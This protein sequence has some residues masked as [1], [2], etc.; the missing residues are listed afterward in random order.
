MSELEE[1][2]HY[3][4]EE[5]EAK[6][7]DLTFP[8][9]HN[10]VTKPGLTPSS[11]FLPLPA[12]SE[13]IQPHNTFEEHPNSIPQAHTKSKWDLPL[14]IT[15]PEMPP[16][17]PVSL[18]LLSSRCIFYKCINPGKELHLGLFVEGYS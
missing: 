2:P 6:K 11:E 7:V 13:G 9:L 18:C 14:P 8:R 15:L 3:T 17:K 4:E 5:T 16:E 12:G 10:K 1:P